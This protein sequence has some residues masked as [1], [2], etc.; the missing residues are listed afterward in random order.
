M[1][2]QR[3]RPEL[4]RVGLIL[5]ERVNQMSREFTNTWEFDSK[6]GFITWIMW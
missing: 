2:A 1:A 4:K 3:E 5:P 6:M